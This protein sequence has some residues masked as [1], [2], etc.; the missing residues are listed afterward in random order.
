MYSRSLIVNVIIFREVHC[1]ICTHT[2]YLHIVCIQY[3]H[4]YFLV[5]EHIYDINIRRCIFKEGKVFVIIPTKFNSMI[6]T[7]LHSLVFKATQ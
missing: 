3:M 2:A 1:H 6:F 4:K 7:E 5:T